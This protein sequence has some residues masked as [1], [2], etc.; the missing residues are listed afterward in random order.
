MSAADSATPIIST[1]NVSRYFSRWDMAGVGRRAG[2]VGRPPK[3]W[4]Y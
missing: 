1:V 2:S 4:Q 3:P